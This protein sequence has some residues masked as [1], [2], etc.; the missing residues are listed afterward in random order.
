MLIF[1]GIAVGAVLS[2]IYLDT[3]TFKVNRETSWSR[4]DHF[5]GLQFGDFR[6]DTS[7]WFSLN[8]SF[9]VEEECVSGQCTPLN[10]TLKLKTING[11]ATDSETE[12][13]E[14]MLTA[15]ANSTN[16]LF[17]SLLVKPNCDAK[18]AKVT[19]VIDLKAFSTTDQ[20]SIVTFQPNQKRIEVGK[21]ETSVYFASHSL[22]AFKT[23]EKWIQLNGRIL[24]IR[25]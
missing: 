23:P 2:V 18:T 1:F 14:L 13:N 10:Y 19:Y 9:R 5:E 17:E 4:F 21:L 6:A 3:R 25:G 7:D 8:Q 22:A 12:S 15:Y 11:L 20:T 24:D 16:D